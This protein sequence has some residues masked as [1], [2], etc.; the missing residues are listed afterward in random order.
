MSAV[1][2]ATPGVSSMFASHSNPGHFLILLNYTKGIIVILGISRNAVA[3]GGRVLKHASGWCQ[4]GRCQTVSN[5]ECNDSTSDD[6][7]LGI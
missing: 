3:L 7:A 4:H 2:Q 1:F 6:F 5:T